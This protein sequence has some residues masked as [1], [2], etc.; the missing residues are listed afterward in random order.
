MFLD[1]V[2]KRSTYIFAAFLLPV[3]LFAQ[4]DTSTNLNKQ[5]FTGDRNVVT[6]TGSGTTFEQIVTNFLATINLAIPVVMSIAAL[7]FFWGVAKFILAAGDENA[8]KEGKQFM[9][10]GI[11][12]LVVMSSIFGIIALLA[13]DI[14][15]GLGI[16][17][18]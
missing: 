7:A 11:I 1:S 4:V 12:G 14:G 9:F 13:G 5:T 8:V 16:P 18:L 10:W 2:K 6:Q 3:V 17:Q 15:G